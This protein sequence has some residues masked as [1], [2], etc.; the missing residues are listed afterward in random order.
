LQPRNTEEDTKVNVMTPNLK[1]TVEPDESK[2]TISDHL[3]E[4]TVKDVSRWLEWYTEEKMK[5]VG[6]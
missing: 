3:A 6:T 1:T 4:G 2:T 5:A